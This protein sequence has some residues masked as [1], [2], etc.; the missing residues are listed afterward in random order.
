LASHEALLILA[1]LVAVYIVLGF[2]TRA[3]FI[4]HHSLNA[5]FAGAARCWQLMLFRQDLGIVVS[6]GIIL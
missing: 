6:I 2:S 4:D 1:A 3:S 5:S